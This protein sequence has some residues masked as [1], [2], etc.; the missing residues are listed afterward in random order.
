VCRNDCL[1][2][3]R[4]T[5]AELRVAQKQFLADATGHV[6][7][8]LHPPVIPHAAAYLIALPDGLNSSYNGH[9]SRAPNTLNPSIGT[10]V[11]SGEAVYK[12]A[13]IFDARLIRSLGTLKAH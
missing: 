7:Q 1:P 4:P 11:L 13:A 5:P 3:P 10:C 12:C 2:T 8:K 6:R 9:E